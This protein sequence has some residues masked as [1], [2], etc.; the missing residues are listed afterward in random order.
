MS[1]PP[2]YAILDTDAVIERGWTAP[3]V[4]RAWLSA[5]VRLIQLRA[6]RLASGPLLELADEIVT[7]CRACGAQV[8]INDRADVAAMAGASGVHVGQQDL[9]PAEARVCVGSSGIVGLST[10]TYPQLVLGAQQPVSY[11]AFGP[12]YA[13]A[14]KDTGYSALGLE[15]VRHAAVVAS[16]AGLPLVA[17]GGMTIERAPWV[18][19]AGAESVAVI[20]DL[21]TPPDLAG[22]EA[23]ARAWVA[24]LD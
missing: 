18:R 17:I 22:V 9:L 23:R 12:V 6:K 16:T 19:E 4:C 14:T 21:L 5:G 1:L 7:L 10:H 11:L 24:G 20:T 13:T 2:L 3:D 15:A 8:I